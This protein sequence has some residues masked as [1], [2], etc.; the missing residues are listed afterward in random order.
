M[1]LQLPHL[2]WHYSFRHIPHVCGQHN[3]THGS[4]LAIV[5]QAPYTPYTVDHRGCTRLHQTLSLQL[6]HW[7]WRNTCLEDS[8]R[9]NR[10]PAK[11]VE[12][13][14]S[15]CIIILQPPCTLDD[16]VYLHVKL[17]HVSR[18]DNLV[19]PCFEQLL[20]HEHDFRIFLFKANMFSCLNM[21]R[22]QT[23]F[24]ACLHILYIVSDQYMYASST[25]FII[26]IM[27]LLCVERSRQA[28]TNTDLSP[29]SV[30]LHTVTLQTTVSSVNIRKRSS[31]SCLHLTPIMAGDTLT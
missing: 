11:Q 18:T 4:Q 13:K 8:Q 10:P 25:V 24:H 29:L 5:Y 7:K 21:L 1:Q 23:C 19:Y 12:D 31:T 15:T 9:T 26:F 22:V 14:N 17:L 3:D 6:E 2:K 27:R 20:V 30:Q 16:H 28:I